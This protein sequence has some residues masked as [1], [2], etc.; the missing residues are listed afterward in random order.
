VPCFS[1][2]ITPIVTPPT[3]HKIAAPTT[4]EIVTGML[5]TISGQTGCWDLNE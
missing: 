4:S 3:S 2:E 5:L 1:A